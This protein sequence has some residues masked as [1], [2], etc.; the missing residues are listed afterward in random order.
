MKTL[1]SLFS[2]ILVVSAANAQA[3]VVG[4]VATYPKDMVTYSLDG[5]GDTMASIQNYTCTIV[6]QKSFSSAAEKAKWD[7]LKRDVKVAYP[8]AVLAKMKL[9]EM[10]AQLA[11]VKGENARKD[12][13]TKCEKELTSQFSNDMRNLTF[14]QGKILFKLMDRETGSTTYQIIKERRGSFSAFMW[15][16]VATIF[17]N[18]LKQDYDPY[19]DDA[20]IE[21]V[22]QLIELGVI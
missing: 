15:Q 12:F 4:E 2:F 20:N 3:L 7:R 21:A 6:A 13:T 22:V 5:N 16:G 17:G 19:G 8:Y 1:L 18:N 9:T 14:T 10:D 11:L